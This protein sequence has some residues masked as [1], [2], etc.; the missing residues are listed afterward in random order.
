[1][2]WTMVARKGPTP[3]GSMPRQLEPTEACPVCSPRRCPQICRKRGESGFAAGL[4]IGPGAGDEGCARQPT[5]AGAGQVA[6]TLCAWPDGLATVVTPG[7]MLSN[8][9][10]AAGAPTWPD[11]VKD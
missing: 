3:P 9:I 5:G 11:E 8:V 2:R 4:R 7:F 10:V 6:A 1:M